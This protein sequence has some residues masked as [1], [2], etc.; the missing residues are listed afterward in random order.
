[1]RGSLKWEADKR[2]VWEG[3]EYDMVMYIRT[4]QSMDPMIKYLTSFTISNFNL[5]T[6]QTIKKISFVR[7]WDP[8]KSL[9]YLVLRRS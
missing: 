6:N 1:M 2:F 4:V 9:I 5:N 7:E 8:C 3:R